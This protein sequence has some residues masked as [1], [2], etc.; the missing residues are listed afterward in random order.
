MKNK[1]LIATASIAVISILPIIYIA[2]VLKNSLK[3][4]DLEGE[5][6]FDGYEESI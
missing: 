3:E 4:L 6:N 2:H 1:K 5:D